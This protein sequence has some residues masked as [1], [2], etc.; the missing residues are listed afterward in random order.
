MG[1]LLFSEDR[2]LHAA[3]TNGELGWIRLASA[4]CGVNNRRSRVPTEK[5]AVQ[6]LV[7]G[8]YLHGR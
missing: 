4:A 6:S 7:P 1:S 5:P 2:K 8:G 3:A